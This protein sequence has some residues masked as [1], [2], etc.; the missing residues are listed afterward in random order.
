MVA[1][2]DL[3]IDTNT[4]WAA[5]AGS[6]NESTSEDPNEDGNNSPS[7]PPNTVDLV[8]YLRTRTLSASSLVSPT[9]ASTNASAISLAIPSSSSSQ[10]SASPNN[11]VSPLSVDEGEQ[12]MPEYVLAM[13]DYAPPEGSTCLSFRAGQ[14]I[15][16]LN[17]DPSGWWDG[18]LEGKRGW[19]PSNF[20]HAEFG[21]DGIEV[22]EE[23]ETFNA[24]M[25]LTRGHGYTRSNASA[26]AAGYDFYMRRPATN[27]D[28]NMESSVP[29]IIVPLYH[30]VTLLQNAVQANRIHHFSPS[31]ATI[32]SCVR[33]ILTATDTLNKDA[34]ILQSYPSLASERKHVLS[35]L[36]SL[37]AQTKRASE[38]SVDEGNLEIE[39]DSM[40]RMAQQ[41]FALVRRFLAVAVQCGIE[42][43]ERRHSQGESQSLG[44]EVQEESQHHKADETITQE[45]REEGDGPVVVVVGIVDSGKTP[46]KTLLRRRPGTPGGRA[47][48]MS[49]L[50]NQRKK[51][52]QQQQQKEPVPPMPLRPG[53]KPEVSVS[54]TAS[55]SSVSSLGTAVRPPKPPFPCGPCTVTQVMEALRFTHDHYLSTIAAFIGHAHTHSRSSHA[56]STGHL[57]ELVG[58]IVEM[59]CKLL[60]IVEAVLQHPDIPN[61]KLAPLRSAKETLYNVTSDLAEAVRLLAA[62]LDPAVSEEEE[63]QS[64][65]RCATLALRSGADL[66][67]AVKLCL[68]R[69]LG[70]RRPFVLNV[71]SLGQRGA[72]STVAIKEQAYQAHHEEEDVTIQPQSGGVCIPVSEAASSSSE[73]GSSSSGGYSKSLSSRSVD[74]P[75]TSREDMRPP[76]LVLSNAPV[77]PDLASPASFMRTDEDAAT[78]WEGST[79]GFPLQSPAL[80]H[81]IF[82]GDLP[83]PP[84]DPI[85]DYIT[86][87]AAYLFG[88][89][90]PTDEIA[91]NTEN[92]LV[93]ATFPALVARLTPHG[94][95]VDSAFSAVFFM[96]FRLFTTPVELVDELIVR[97]HLP[98]P[99]GLTPELELVWEQ[100]K[101]IPVRLRIANFIKLW[102]ESF[103]RPET[104][105]AA[106]GLLHS[107]TQELATLFPG[108]GERI[109]QMIRMYHERRD[110][111]VSPRG[112]RT[113]DPGMLLNPPPSAVSL[114]GETPRPLMNKPL[115][116]SLK[117]K[118]FE[119]IV[120]TDFDA[121]ELARQLTIMECN[122]Y[123]AI[124][125]EEVLESGQEGAKPPVNV[126]AVSSLSTT[127]TGWVAE[128]ILN[129]RDM[130]KRTALVKF[131]VKVADKCIT[132]HNFSTFRSILAALDSSTIARLHQTWN[133]LPQKSKVQ[134]ES[135][136][137]LADH[138]RNYR[139][140][141]ARLR[142]TAP[143]A[144]P[145]LG[146]YLTDITFCR[147]GNPSHRASPLN[148]DKKLLNFNKY[149]KLARIVQDMQRFQVPYNLRVIAEVQEYLEFVFKESRKKGD[150]QD[151]YRRSLLVEPKQPADT[152][153]TSQLFAWTRS[154]SSSSLAP[155]SSSS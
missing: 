154:Q 136:R 122:L 70:E 116:A 141:R 112:D 129:E 15:H 86:D 29:P 89:D 138:S 108:P 59:S 16:V 149:H 133:G 51:Q 83:P 146:L 4:A 43:P 35:S 111:M 2:Q 56:S 145:F 22:G 135:M 96:T 68:T 94:S 137:R 132:L 72:P 38:E 36:A 155:P 12:Q 105:N 58:E 30:T 60:A 78:T 63:K 113:R 41:L 49:D 11:L 47:K 87:P 19:F 98:K 134:L 44:V 61:Q 21:E 140:Y 18:E 123:C 71:P 107:F 144:V 130:K 102:L 126:R 28:I 64:L 77:E 6:E 75:M 101:G 3:R 104:D 34:P 82:N 62:P 14:V 73:G 151:L 23:D 90:Y 45:D 152:P 106:L 142:N 76:P 55:S 117:A 32:I 1:F 118:N 85:P 125:Q 115:F 67:A 25:P 114:S 93:G 39:I 120:I 80:E 5:L 53:H 52:Q 127:I 50:R 100:N 143:P 128:S 79:R 150:L 65:L 46:T 54:S 24:R 27:S 84:S 66:A 8:E 109:L 48:S 92:M 153:P 91:Y 74:T 7:P 95:V 88:Q 139:E 97:Y 69:S 37:V 57:Y 31:T 13:H 10:R 9:S 110:P 121:L 148:P 26:P 103:W 99:Q 119:S 147:E 20:V 124:T 17:R 131:F 81:K 33:A 40:L 42:L